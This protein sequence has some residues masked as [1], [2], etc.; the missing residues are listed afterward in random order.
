M[1]KIKALMLV[2]AIM[3]GSSVF[4]GGG[5]MSIMSATL[6][7][8]LVQSATQAEQLFKQATMVQQQ[9]QMLANQARNLQ[10]LPQQ[11]WPNVA[12]QL[13]QLIQINRQARGLSYGM[14][15]VAASMRQQYGDFGQTL[16]GVEQRYKDWNDNSNSQLVSTLQSYGYQADNFAT[17]Q[18][19]LAQVQAA[20]QSATGRMQALQAGNQI[21][22][23]QVNQ[24]QMLRLA[25]MQ[26]N[27]AMLNIAGN[28]A[29]KEQQ[30]RNVVN[31]WLSRPAK[32]GVW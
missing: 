26:G 20:S 12:S 29:N 27:Q 25:V 2:V 4:A 22:A 23:M 21:A 5:G 14:T 24:T 6:P 7:E 13:T 32:R 17:E 15:D 30:D 28:K 18:D 8:Q 9:I 10:N 16:I 19:A 31:E 3:F 1:K 11:F